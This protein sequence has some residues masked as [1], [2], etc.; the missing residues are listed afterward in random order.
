[1]HEK[2]TQTCLANAENTVFKFFGIRVMN[3]ELI[4]TTVPG[5]IEK[6][7]SGTIGF[8]PESGSYVPYLYANRWSQQFSATA[9]ATFMFTLKDDNSTMWLGDITG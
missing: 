2:L 5:Q 8:K 3:S 7:F 1:M 6:N 9:R 4:N